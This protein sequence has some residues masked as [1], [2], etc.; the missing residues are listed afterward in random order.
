M[1]DKSKFLTIGV[2]LVIG[3]VIGASYA[4]SGAPLPF[5]DNGLRSEAS[6]D[7][8]DYRTL[9]ALA[10]LGAYQGYVNAPGRVTVLCAEGEISLYTVLR[11]KSNINPEVNAERIVN[12]T[13][14]QMCIAAGLGPFQ[15]YHQTQTGVLIYC[16]TGNISWRIGGGGTN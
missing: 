16:T 10:G 7:K 6:Y 9:C 2:S 4:S 1:I 3:L 5:R 15:G 14:A 8:P 12:P 11:D 13:Y